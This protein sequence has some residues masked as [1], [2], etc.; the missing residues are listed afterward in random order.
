[1]RTKTLLLT[2]AV[3]AVGA[4]ASQ[5]QVYSVNA[6]GYVNMSFPNGGLALIANPLNGTNNNI[7]TILPTV[8]VD[9]QMFKWNGT[10]YND[11]EFFVDG[12]GWLNGMGE[13]STTVLAPGEGFFLVFP[14]TSPVTITFVGEVPQGNLTNNVPSGFSIRASQVPQSVGVSS[15]GFPA[16]ADDTLFFWNYGTQTWKDGIQYLGGGQWVNLGTGDTM[17]PAPAV[18]EGFFVVSQSGG[19][20]TRSFSVN[21]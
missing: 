15:I 16:T 21:N 18:G 13:P 14:N 5:A 10:A 11:A 8:P 7:N 17:D 1:M 9:T 20:W 3:I 19:N 6:V 4:I 12:V 2:A